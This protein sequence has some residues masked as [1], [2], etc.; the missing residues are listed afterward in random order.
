MSTWKFEDWAGR[1]Y[2]DPNVGHVNPGDT[3]EADEPPDHQFW[4]E[5]DPSTVVVDV[6]PQTETDVPVVTSGYLQVVADSAQ[7]PA[8]DVDATAHENMTNE[9]GPSPVETEKGDA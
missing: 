9:G 1:I 4:T 6:K 5:V 8:N 2:D 3:I 7:V